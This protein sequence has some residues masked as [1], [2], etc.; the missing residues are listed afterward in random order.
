VVGSRGKVARID[1][2]PQ[3]V[4]GR[5]DLLPLGRLERVAQA[6]ADPL[7]RC[8]VAHHAV[9]IMSGGAHAELLRP[10]VEA[11]DV[12]GRNRSVTQLEIQGETGD[13]DRELRD[14]AGAVGMDG[15]GEFAQV[16]GEALCDERRRGRF[17]RRPR[18]E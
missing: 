14:R 10:E 1:G 13:I 3:V 7:E 9:E 17:D 6:L 11:L 16:A 8:D 4:K 12:D 18:I 15:A 2:L 5:V